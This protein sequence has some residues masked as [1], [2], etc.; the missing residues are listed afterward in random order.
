MS[1]EAVQSFDQTSLKQRQRRTQQPIRT[2]SEHTQF[3]SFPLTCDLSS[4]RAVYRGQK[5]GSCSTILKSAPNFRQLST[6]D[7]FSQIFP[8]TTPPYHK[9]CTSSFSME[10]PL[11]METNIEQ[12]KVA[13]SSI[14]G[15]Q[16]NM[17]T[18][19]PTIGLKSFNQIDQ[20]KLTGAQT[21]PANT[22]DQHAS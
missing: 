22:T 18:G 7:L 4:R 16:P 15:C 12:N 6:K 21:K 17:F 11:S 14:T 8:T 3:S 10:P 2:H 9:S 13:L 20:W 1:K 5:D 19:Q